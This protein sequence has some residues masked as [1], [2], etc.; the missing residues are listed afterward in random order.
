MLPGSRPIAELAEVVELRAPNSPAAHYLDALH[1]RR[2]NREYP[3]DPDA[4]RNLANGERGSGPSTAT[5]NADP[6]KRLDPLLGPLADA[7][8]HTDRI[9]RSEAR[10][11]VPEVLLFEFLKQI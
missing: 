8:Q 9:P 6:F 11:V 10:K 1:R 4:S 3:L 5:S 7:V 2:V